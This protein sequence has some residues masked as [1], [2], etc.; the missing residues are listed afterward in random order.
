MKPKPLPPF[1]HFV[2]FAPVTLAVTGLSLLAIGA[3]SAAPTVFFKNGSTIFGS[4]SSW[5]TTDGGTTNISSFGTADTLHFAESGVGTSGTVSLTTG[6]SIS[7]GA[8][9]LDRTGAA[10]TLGN[11]VIGTVGDGFTLTLNGNTDYSDSSTSGIVL[12]SGTPN[13]SALTI[14]TNI[15]L[16]ASQQW[17]NGRNSGGGLTVNGAVNLGANTLSF[18]AVTGATTTVNGNIT[19]TGGLATNTGTGTTVLTSANGYTGS[20][21]LANGVLRVT[22]TGTLGGTSGSSTTAGNIFF[23]GATNNA[24]ALEFENAANLGAASQ[25]RFS[26]GSGTA[27]QGGILR[28]IGTTDTTITKTLYCDTSIGLRIESDSVGGSL[29]VIGTF[30]QSNRPLY[31]G[32]TGTGDNTLT[33]SFTGSGALT[34][35]GAGKWIL[36]GSNSYSGGTIINAG[37]LVAGVGDTSTTVSAFGGSSR[38]VSLGDTTGSNNTS[39]LI[40]GAFTVGNTITVQTGSTGNT[41]T[42]GGSTAAASSFTGASIFLGSAGGV[43]VKDATFVAATGGSVDFTGIIRENVSGAGDANVT[44]GNATN[45]GTVK[46]S[47]TLNAYDGITTINGGTL[48][49]KA[50]AANGSSSSI[51]NG[52]AQTL[53]NSAQTLVISGGTLKFT[54]TTGSGSTNR[55]FTIGTNGATIEGSSS[56]NTALIFTGTGLLTT[57]AGA[58]DRTLDLS[59]ATTAA[60]LNSIAS[61][62]VDPTGGGKTLLTKSGT[63]TWVLSGANTYT[64]ATNVNTGTLVINGSTATGSAVTVAD[65]ATLGGSGKV[66]GATT[67]ENGG[68]HDVGGGADRTQ[69]FSGSLTYHT[70]SIFSWDLDAGASDTGSGATN[71]GTYDHVIAAGAVTKDAGAGA[72]FNIVLGGTDTFADPFWNTAKSWSNIFTTGTG[73][74][75][76]ATIFTSFGGD[77]PTTGIVS[78]RGQFTF[79]TNTLTW[80]A[81]PEPTS[82]LAGVLLAA[83]LLRRRRV[84]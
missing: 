75:S 56:D 69:D 30:S 19:G 53:A 13:L 10:G 41:I 38:A 78:D 33:Q 25:I 5:V 35:Y 58:T 79:I 45:L 8:V 39:L 60:T 40:G 70:G 72:I 11:V 2:T 81:V 77:V 73:S 67:I 42:L 23:T 61:I 74:E 84:A 20:T 6:S 21:A 64:G 82:A 15:A 52:S 34:K 14:N 46:F 28:Y 12:N 76:L 51:G 9:R 17:V 32:G 68:T 16:G 71:S 59:G 31:L 54:G 66:G 37:T 49:A 50:F 48:E 83:G 80:S 57:T 18:F 44:V 63:N 26:N 4:T 62:I 65:D 43:A 36:A 29:N 24:T 22:G 7:V 47:N 27:G 3:A 1:A 55:L